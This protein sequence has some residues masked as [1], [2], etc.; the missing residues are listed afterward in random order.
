MVTDVI[1]RMVR[2]VES[3]TPQHHLDVFELGGI[4]TQHDQLYLKSGDGVLVLVM[5]V[6]YT[7]LSTKERRERAELIQAMATNAPV[8][9]IR[10]RLTD[11]IA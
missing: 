4:V 10:A 6:T 8:Q 5:D 9:D 2:V 1:A 7:P 11:L 3:G